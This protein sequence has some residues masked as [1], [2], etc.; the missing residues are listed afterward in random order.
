MI[1]KDIEKFLLTHE[2][3]ADTFNAHMARAVEGWQPVATVNQ[4]AQR[5]KDPKVANAINELYALAW[6]TRESS[7]D[8]K[9]LDSLK[10]KERKVWKR[11]MAIVTAILNIRAMTEH[12]EL[13][14]EP[15]PEPA[16]TTERDE[17]HAEAMQIL[18]TGDPMEYI[19]E[20]VNMVHVGDEQSVRML[21]STQGCQAVLNSR[22]EHPAVNGGSGTGKTDL[23][24][25][26]AHHLPPEMVK[27]TSLSD[28]SL[29]YLN[30]SP[31]T[32]LILDDLEVPEGLAPTLKRCTSDWSVPVMH[33]TL[34]KQ[35]PIE[36]KIPPYIC[37]MFANVDM[38]DDEQ[39]LNRQVPL[40]VD[41]SA[42]MDERVWR[43]QM[44]SLQKHRTAHPENRRVQVC[45]EIMRIIK[46]EHV[47]VDV[48]LR[49]EDVVWNNKQNRRNFDVFGD[50]LKSYTSLFRYQRETYK[51]GEVRVI[52]AAVD[53]F[54]MAARLYCTRAESQ[55]TKLS[56]IELKIVRYLQSRAQVNGGTLGSAT[57]DEI[58]GY[59]T[60][61]RSRVYELLHGRD[62]KGGLLKKLAALQYMPQNITDELPGDERRTRPKNLYV[63]DTR[64]LPALESYQSTVMLSPEFVETLDVE[65]RRRLG[66]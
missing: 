30:L 14:A 26:V 55:A 28:K 33:T 35:T 10:G 59:L 29:Y 32:T 64:K 37:W 57:I 40:E 11:A 8:G 51:D 45:R 15:A 54:V 31:G 60:K 61:S 42:E 18:E 6:A 43:H 39:V 12:D 21:I 53:D 1:D 2:P 4:I 38:G 52:V 56:G 48:P 66:L 25:A 34:I 17:I 44:E 50:V 49:P 47:Y 65:T 46:T 22:G 41:E 24:R 27:D 13:S 62:G 63:L 23:I 9:D 36:L 20:S 3:G 58:Q 5:M 16:D 19:R 7:I